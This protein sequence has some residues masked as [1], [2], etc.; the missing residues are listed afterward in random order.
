MTK[1]LV[2]GTDQRLK[3]ANDLL[4]AAGLTSQYIAA[5]SFDDQLKQ[6]LIDERP[7]HLL[8]PLLPMEPCIPAEYLKEGCSVYTGQSSA[9]WR[10]ELSKKGIRH[11]NYLQDEQFIWKNAQLTA[12]AFVH[13]FYEQTK[14]QIAGKQF[15]IAGFG[16]VGKAIAHT[17]HQMQAKVIIAARSDEQLAEAHM[18]GYGTQRL[19]ERTE[20]SRGYLVNTIPAQWL[21]ADQTGT[22]HVFDVSSAP[23]CLKH[24]EFSEYYTIHLK[25]PGKHFPEDAAAVLAEAVLRM[26][27]DERGTRCLKENESD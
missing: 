13:V 6:M 24:G 7:D 20:F 27:I 17:L 9:Q 25:L 23:G 11:I 1:W 26:S 2:A 16:R 3:L 10:Q 19:T 8:L 18:L 12:E 14:R 22:V 21:R 5:D 15:Y 4:L